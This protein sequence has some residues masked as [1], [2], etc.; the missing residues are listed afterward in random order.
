[1]LQVLSHPLF[2]PV[3][4]ALLTRSRSSPSNIELMHAGLIPPEEL[5]SVT[6]SVR[7]DIIQNI[8]DMLFNEI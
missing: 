6:K 7:D 4:T 3:M 5:V 1:M 2:V 8:D